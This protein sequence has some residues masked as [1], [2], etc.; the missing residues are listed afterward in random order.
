MDIFIL[1]L[2]SIYL[3]FH[4]SISLDVQ[5]FDFQDNHAQK[6]FTEENGA[7]TIVIKVLNGSLNK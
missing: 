6:H 7:A 2:F 1:F 3:L 5:G 4:I